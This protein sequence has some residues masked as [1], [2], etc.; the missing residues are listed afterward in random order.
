MWFF[1]SVM[2]CNGNPAKEM[3]LSLQRGARR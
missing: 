3:H 2:G 1:S